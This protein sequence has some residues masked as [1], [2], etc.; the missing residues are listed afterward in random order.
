M[1]ASSSNAATARAVD[2]QFAQGCAR[3]N[4]ARSTYPRA[5]ANAI[6]P[7]SGDRLCR[8]GERP[9]DAVLEHAVAV[10]GQADALPT[11]CGMPELGA[12]GDRRRCRR[13]LRH[14]EPDLS[15]GR[16]GRLGGAASSS[17]R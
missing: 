7:R 10:P 3:D 13:R 11:S 1:S 5:T 16:P 14:E 17:G 9:L 6:E 2:E 15:R 8:S 12:A 4:A